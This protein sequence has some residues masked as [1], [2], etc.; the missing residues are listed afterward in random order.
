[1][2]DQTEVSPLACEGVP[3]SAP[4]R[5]SLCFFR[6]PLPASPWTPLAGRFPSLGEIQAYHV[7]LVCQDGLGPRLFAGDAGCLRE[8]KLD[9]PLPVTVPFWFKPVSNFGLFAFTTFNNGSPLLA[10]SST[11]ALQP[12]WC[13]QL[14][15]PLTVPSLP[16]SRRYLVPRAF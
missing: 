11:L 8:G 4:L 10:I 9:T 7:P 15:L 5:R 14:R 6:H 12:L 3:L 1:M 16:F 2:K 13:E